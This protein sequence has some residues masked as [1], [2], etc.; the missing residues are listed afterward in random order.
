MLRQRVATAAILLAVLVPSI[1]LAR[2]WVWGLVSLALLA[3]AGHEWGKLLGSSRG[4]WA[5]GAGLAAAGAAYVGWR[6]GH[7]ADAVP[8]AVG[9]VAAVSLAF[10]VSIGTL[11]LARARTVGPGWAIGPLVLAA[12]WIA[13]YELRLAGAAMLV[14]A[15]AIVWLADVGAYF[16]GRTFGRRRLAPR[17]SPGKTWEGVAGGVIAV[18][19]A[20]ALVVAAVPTPES[21]FPGWIA[22]R[23]GWLA[24]ALVL[25]AVAGLSVVGDLYESLLKR[26]AGAKDS[27]RILPGH[28]GV[29]DRIDALIPTMPGC[30]LLLQVLR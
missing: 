13:L 17:I 4:G 1:V 22:A 26:Q 29:L 18:L 24:A 21:L 23:A 2:P 8:P 10:W 7:A 16:A 30:L 5:L 25:A 11:S 12:C 15:M 20:A 27:G 28:G 9:I 14:S 19:A 3:V 6:T